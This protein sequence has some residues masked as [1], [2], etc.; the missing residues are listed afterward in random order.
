MATVNDVLRATLKGTMLDGVQWNM[1][2]HYLVTLGTSNDYIA[3][4]GA[5]ETQIQAAFV[6][7]EAQLHNSVQTDDLILAEWDFT[8]NEFDGKVQLI[9]DAVEGAVAAEAYPNQIAILMR[10][11]TAELRRQARKYVPGVH[12][13]NAQGNN[14][15]AATVA[16]AATTAAILN[17]TFAADLLTLHP[18]TFNSTPTSPRFETS[19]LLSVTD[20]FIN[21]GPGTQRRRVPGAGI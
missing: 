20:F 14:I 2:Y 6:A 8:D 7:L 13:T 10:F 1:V 16:A 19:S 11:P 3:I 15:G 21:T 5:I 18:C 12:E 4:A 17:N 9:S